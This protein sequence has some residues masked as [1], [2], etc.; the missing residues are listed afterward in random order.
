[1]DEGGAAASRC[2]E[3]RGRQRR[4]ALSK[5]GT[6]D[7]YLG[8][9]INRAEM[10]AE[11]QRDVYDDSLGFAEDKDLLVR[12]TRA[13]PRLPPPCTSL[14]LSHDAAAVKLVPA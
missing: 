11:E 1:M 7:G 4:A 9:T 13:Q 12:A 14:A 2:G 5:E 10:T 6:M 3:A 8:C